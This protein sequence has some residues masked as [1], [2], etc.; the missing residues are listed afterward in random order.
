M[1]QATLPGLLESMRRHKYEADIRQDS[2]QILTILKI[3]KQEYPLFLRIFENSRLLQLLVFIP[4]TLSAATTV[5]TARLLHLLNKEVDMPGFGMDEM[6]NVIFY[7][8]MIPLQNKKVDEDL[9]IT[10]L[11]AAQNICELFALPVE[12]VA[13]G[14]ATLDEILEKVKQSEQEQQNQS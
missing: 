12:A 2:K 1:I 6:A 11:K 3:S 10:Y 5:D 13:N 9:F 4:T 8:L 14:Q 7:R